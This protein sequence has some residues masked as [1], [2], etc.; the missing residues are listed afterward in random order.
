MHDPQV[1]KLIDDGANFYCRQLGN[2]SHMQ[3]EDN[4]IY[5]MIYPKPGQQGG[6]SLFN[7]RLDAL[8]DGDT[9]RAIDEIKAL[10]VHTWWGLCL[11]DRIADMV[12]G[13]DRPVL[14]PEEH[15]NDEELY[16]ALFPQEQPAGAAPPEGVEIKP[17]VSAEQF[18]VWADIC[19]TVLHGGFPII[20]RVYHWDICRDGIMP[21]YIAYVAG[22]PAAVCAVL[23]NADEASLEFVATAEGFRKRGLADALCRRAVLDAFS[24]GARVV[25]TR[26]FADA[27]NIYKSLG[28]RV[29]Y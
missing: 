10:D 12:W 26:A 9:Q 2:A 1:M 17:V 5:S 7:V 27:K 6:T 20:N 14:T 16:M 15:E 25:T 4:G 23:R 21:S 8:G 24:S 3:F 13:K 11:P 19:N 29:Y 18:A 22:K 28:F